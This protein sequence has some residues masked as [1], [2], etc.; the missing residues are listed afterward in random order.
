[1]VRSHVF[2][3]HVVFLCEQETDSKFFQNFFVFLQLQV[4]FDAERFET[5]GCAGFARC[6]AVSVFRNCDAA[7]RDHKGCCCGDV[8]GIGFISAGSDDFQNIL[9]MFHVNTVLSHAVG[10]CGDLFDCLAFHRHG[11]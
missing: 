2:H 6:G 5:V 3:G 8:E 7:C 4:D 9:V 10:T 11:S 1:M